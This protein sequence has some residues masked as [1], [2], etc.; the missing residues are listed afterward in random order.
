MW[1]ELGD[2][3][4][5]GRASS[6]QL[7]R[8]SHALADPGPRT[9]TPRRTPAAPGPSLEERGTAQ[10][11]RARAAGSHR[12]S[13]PGAGRGE[14]RHG[15]GGETPAGTCRSLCL[16]RAAPVASPPPSALP[17]AGSLPHPL[18]GED[19]YPPAVLDPLHPS[20]ESGTQA[21]EG[22]KRGWPWPSRVKALSPPLVTPQGSLHLKF[23]P[24]PSPSITPF[25]PANLL[26]ILKKVMTEAGPGHW[27]TTSELPLKSL[28]AGGRVGR[29]PTSIL[30]GLPVEETSGS[31]SVRTVQ[32]PKEWRE[33]G[34]GYP[35]ALR[36]SQ[37][38]TSRWH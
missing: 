11:V 33:V 26:L 25:C 3:R 17:G 16:P 27:V 15:G 1:A 18:S 35:F 14:C 12:G 28:F 6:P 9:G 13:Q 8:P 19:G 30:L 22:D 5:V 29:G 36:P 34:L 24:D 38:L 32:E 10:R 21:L 20:C 31:S 37:A 4:G 7:L 23:L 2:G